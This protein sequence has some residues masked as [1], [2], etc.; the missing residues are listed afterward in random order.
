MA[1]FILCGINPDG[2]TPLVCA[3]DLQIVDNHF[4]I[5]ARWLLMRKIVK[6]TVDV[7]GLIG[8]LIG[9]VY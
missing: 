4:D 7:Y 9:T 2:K 6:I 3:V 5:V 1:Y 8:L